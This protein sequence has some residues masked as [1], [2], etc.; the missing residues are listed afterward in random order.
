MDNALSLSMLTSAN[1]AQQTMHWTSLIGCTVIFMHQT[2]LDRHDE[3][4]IM[5][6][7]KIASDSLV[8]ECWRCAERR[9]GGALAQDGR[10][11][12]AAQTPSATAQSP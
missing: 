2:I 7:S 1:A 12:P 8:A 9:A 3:P 6:M 11:E 4:A 10:G 5:R